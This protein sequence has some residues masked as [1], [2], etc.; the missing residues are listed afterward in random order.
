MMN[1]V[2]NRV[3]LPA[4]IAGTQEQFRRLFYNVRNN[5]WNNCQGFAY[6]HIAARDLD[7]LILNTPNMHS[8]E[9]NDA[10]ARLTTMIRDVYDCSIDRAISI[11]NNVYIPTQEE[12]IHLCKKE[13]GKNENL[14]PWV[15]GVYDSVPAEESGWFNFCLNKWN[16]FHKE[17]ET[18]DE[19]DRGCARLLKDYR[20]QIEVEW[21]QLSPEEQQGW[22]RV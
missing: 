14:G 4:D 18:I 8:G 6:I 3:S 2:T 22:C 12:Y 10:K 20:Q 9:I 21:S 13:F 16:L 11:L 15:E 17:H 19:A 5:D 7:E 1:Q